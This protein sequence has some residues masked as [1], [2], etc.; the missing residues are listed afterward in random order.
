[1]RK[2]IILFL[3]IASNVFSQLEQGKQLGWQ[4]G[5]K[6]SALYQY[7]LDFDGSTEY[8]SCTPALRLTGEYSLYDNFSD[9][10]YNGWTVSSGAYSVVDSVPLSGGTKSL[11]CTTAGI[12][13]IP[14]NLS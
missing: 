8:I 2:L 3:L 11:K 10:N 9:G 12:I 14:C 4:W 5:I 7:A 1:M 6:K 13:S